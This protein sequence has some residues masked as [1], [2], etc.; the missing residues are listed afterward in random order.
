MVPLLVPTF[1][2]RTGRIPN[3]PN[4]L[5]TKVNPFLR[6]RPSFF[7]TPIVSITC[8]T[9]RSM[10]GRCGKYKRERIGVHNGKLVMVK[11]EPYASET[12]GQT[13]RLLWE[14]CRPVL[15]E[16]AIHRALACG[17]AV[18]VAASEATK[19]RLAG[20]L[21]RALSA[22]GALDL[23]GPERETFEGIAES[24]RL[25]A[26]LLIPAAVALAV[27]PLTDIG[28]EPVVYKGPAVARRYP[29]PGLRP[30]DDIDLLL[31]RESHHDALAVLQRAGWK[32]AR[33]AGP[34]AYDTALTHPEV[35]SLFLEL[36]YG[37][38][39]KSER[40]TALDP[41]SLW[42]RRRPIECA[43][44]PAFGLSPTDEVVVL[45]TH[46]GKPFHRF[47]RL[48]WIADLAMLAHAEERAGTAVDWLA[49]HELAKETG[50]LT[51]VG[52]ALSMARRVGVEIPGDLFHL[53]HRGWRGATIRRLTAES[54]PLRQLEVRNYRLNY[55][56][57]DRLD[58][59]LRRLLVILAAR[60]RFLR[61][62]S[63]A[64][65]LS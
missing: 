24:F 19:H 1:F 8:E 11:V 6:I 37:L 28:L 46:A 29:H 65:S 22:A 18:P 53:P 42:T 2:S 3:S 26:L 58:Q 43:G 10:R 55:A 45:A 39:K 48:I 50:C 41:E 17:A 57:V 56:I 14:S 51:V 4:G 49:V 23:L 40:V 12:T 32:V 7:V 44:T 60:Y 20:L 15:D 21:C 30:M 25:E 61:R 62:Q 36:H 63:R 59:R 47:V 35:P 38:E 13:A 16:S 31:P 64:R 34:K 33:P 54:W 9:N 5:I 27:Q 52:V